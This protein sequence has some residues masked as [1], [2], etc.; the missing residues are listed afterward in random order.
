MEYDDDA[1]DL[2]MMEDNVVAV[3]EDEN[4]VDVADEE[5]LLK[6]EKMMMCLL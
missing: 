5:L 2:I 1:V 3:V 4:D 6:L